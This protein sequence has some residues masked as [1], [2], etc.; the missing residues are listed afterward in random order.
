VSEPFATKSSVSFNQYAK[1]DKSF[2]FR[3]LKKIVN[4][5]VGFRGSDL[6]NRIV[7]FWT[8]FTSIPATQSTLTALWETDINFNW[9]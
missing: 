5:K 9:P 7:G 3:F 1:S 2:G 8:L 4:R 6:K